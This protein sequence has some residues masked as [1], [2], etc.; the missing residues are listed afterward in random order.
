[1]STWS[2]RG[3]PNSVKNSGTGVTSLG[4]PSRPMKPTCPSAMSNGPTSKKVAPS[5]VSMNRPSGLRGLLGSAPGSG[6]VS[7][8]DAST[9]G[10]S[11][12]M[13]MPVPRMPMV[14]VR[15]RTTKDWEDCLPM[16]PVKAR[17]PPLSSDS[18]ALLLACGR[19]YT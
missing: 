9:Q 12:L 4:T 14:E 6:G 15:V 2:G 10:P 11:Q 18:T 3:E 8:S 7:P 19:L 1:M 17:S 5:Q 16:K 13:S